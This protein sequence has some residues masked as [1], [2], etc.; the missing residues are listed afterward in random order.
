M[1]RVPKYCLHKATGQGIARINGKD[2]YF[3]PYDD[4]ASKA[5]YLRLVTEFA[6]SKFSSLFSVDTEEYTMAGLAVAYLNYAKSYYSH[7]TEYV[8]LQLAMGPINALYADHKASEFGPKQFKASRQW[9]IDKRVSRQYVN[10]QAK[11]LVRAIKWGVSEGII[12]ASVHHA[13]KC[14]DPLKRGRCEAKESPKILPVPTSTVLATL[15]CLPPVVADMVRFQLLVGCRPGEVCSITPSMVDRSDDVWEINLDKHKTAWRGKSR[16]IFVGPKAQDVLRPYLLRG[17]DSFC[18]SPIE[19]TKQ[20][21]QARHEARLT[22]L[23]CGNKP[24]SK[25]VRIALKEP[26]DC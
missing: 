19:A 16:T 23:S 6:E 18:F 5:K 25:R 12:P 11:R 9:W 1:A 13:I 8:N 26:S 7:G 15:P 22:A 14:V 10:K 4:P 2:H 24:G 21:R 3:G 20:R 17:A